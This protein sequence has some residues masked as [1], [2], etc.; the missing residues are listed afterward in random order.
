MCSYNQG[1]TPPAK[2]KTQKHAFNLFKSTLLSQVDV[3]IH[4]PSL[5]W[6]NKCRRRRDV[7]VCYDGPLLSRPSSP[8][9]FLISPPW[10]GKSNII[11]VPCQWSALCWVIT[12]NLQR[13]SLGLN[14]QMF[15]GCPP[16]SGCTRSINKAKAA[17]KSHLVRKGGG[18]L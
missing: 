12:P 13:L 17:A 5:P 9:F 18:R 11:K 3:N 4:L 2:N 16:S 10:M 8:L 14:I 6:S 1:V 15:G 7:H